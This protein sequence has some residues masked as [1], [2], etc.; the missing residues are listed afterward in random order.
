MANAAPQLHPIPDYNLEPRD[1][2]ANAIQLNSVPNSLKPQSWELYV[3]RIAPNLARQTGE[4]VQ[5][6]RN[7]LMTLFQPLPHKIMDTE[8]M[9]RAMDWDDETED[10]YST[11]PAVSRSGVV[12]KKGTPANADSEQLFTDEHGI[13]VYVDRENLQEID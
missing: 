10:P 7:Q 4:S 1:T 5:E 6:V 12:S 9:L 13:P 2:I 11:R 3:E 8:A